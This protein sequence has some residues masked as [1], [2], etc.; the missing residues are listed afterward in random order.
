MGSIVDGRT[1]FECSNM[2]DSLEFS[3]TLS[4]SAI[5]TCK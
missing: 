4:A 3:V 2:R 5:T 1:E